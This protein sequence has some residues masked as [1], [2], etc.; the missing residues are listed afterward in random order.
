MAERQRAVVTYALLRD[1]VA[2]RHVCVKVVLAIEEGP[3]VDLAPE[4]NRS[5]QPCLYTA[6]VEGGQRTRCSGVENRH[7]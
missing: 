6:F 5:Q 1:L 2:I 4:R 7:L 3:L